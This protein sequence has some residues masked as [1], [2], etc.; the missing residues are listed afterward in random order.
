ME[1]EDER[2]VIFCRATVNVI[3]VKAGLAKNKKTY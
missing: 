1:G 2:K 3:I